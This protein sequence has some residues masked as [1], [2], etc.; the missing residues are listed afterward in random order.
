MKNTILIDMDSDREDVIRITKTENLVES[1][2]DVESAKKMILEDITTICQAL[3][4][5]IKVGN[6]S[7]YFKDTDMSKMCIKYLNDNFKE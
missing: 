2:K 7:E 1:I 6:D 3:G 5:L 4:T